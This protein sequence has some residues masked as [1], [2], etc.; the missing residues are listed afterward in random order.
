MQTGEF[1]Q[2]IK[3]SDNQKVLELL[4]REP[5]LANAVDADGTSAVFLALYRGNAQLAGEVAS[6]KSI[7]D[8]FEAACLGNLEL[9][10][11]LVDSD[12]S[13]VKSHS[14]DGFTA[15]ALAA[16]VGQKDAA[17][18]LISRGADP[19]SVAKNE[20]GFTA[21]TGAVSQNHNE[22][23]R[24][25]IKNGANVNYAYEGGF[26]PLMHATAAGNVELVK[27]LLDGGADPRIKNGEG[28]T[29]LGFATENKHRDVVELLKQHGAM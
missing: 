25:L 7:I 29:A 3:K 13:L 28:R 6:R 17:E 5:S 20:T 23:A 4:K 22:I 26:T 24:L 9:V 12:I 27:I 14:P 2:A 16:Y 21:L 1:I 10:K 11:R 8:V 15:L 19:N 18:Y